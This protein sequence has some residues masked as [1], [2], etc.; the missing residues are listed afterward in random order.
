MSDTNQ[1]LNINADDA[2]E[3][4]LDSVPWANVPTVTTLPEQLYD[5]EVIDVY[6]SVWPEKRDD[7]GHVVEGKAYVAVV[8]QAL[9]P[10]DFLGRQHTE[11]FTVGS[12]NDPRAQRIETWLTGSAFGAVGL[13]KLLQFTG[14]ANWREL[15]SKR[16]SAFTRNSKGSQ[17]DREF[18][19][20]QQ[21]QYYNLGEVLPGTV[22]TQSASRSRKQTVRPGATA[23]GASTANSS[24]P[25]PCPTCQQNFE[26][27]DIIDHVRNCVV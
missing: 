19:N 20:L 23:N 21:A 24:G 4:I 12:D 14:C 5:W 16:F 22:T 6:G 1:N 18:T 7:A 25:V 2:I 3:A 17:G 15:R 10:P 8:L 13:S 9:A 27:S 26:P 11:N